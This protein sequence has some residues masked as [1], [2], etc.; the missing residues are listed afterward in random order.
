MVLR[1]LPSALSRK[2]P[3]ASATRSYVPARLVRLGAAPQ[4]VPKFA[5]PSAYSE[6]RGPLQ[7]PKAV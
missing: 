1:R 6:T 4:P 7:C 3:P 2:V 5:V